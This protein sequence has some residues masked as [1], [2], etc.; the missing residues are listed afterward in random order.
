MGSALGH[1][2]LVKMIQDTPS[3]LSF[4]QSNCLS[5]CAYSCTAAACVCFWLIMR[6]I[7]S[8]LVPQCSLQP[9]PSKMSQT[10]Q[11]GNRKGNRNLLFINTIQTNFIWPFSDG[12]KRRTRVSFKK[13][14]KTEIILN[15]RPTKRQKAAKWMSAFIQ[16]CWLSQ[17]T[18]SDQI[19]IMS[20][21]QK[22]ILVCLVRSLSVPSVRL[23][24]CPISVTVLTFWVLTMLTCC[25]ERENCKC[26]VLGGPKCWS[27]IEG[28]SGRWCIMHHLLMSVIIW[29]VIVSFAEHQEAKNSL[30]NKLIDF[31][32]VYL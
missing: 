10:P 22:C 8:P 6:L 14:K 27:E 16:N 24:I 2:E 9:F 13:N 29:N 17:D 1:G 26:E 31:E 23:C 5:L 18:E 25:P 12:S 7:Y 4:S 19:C 20:E 30:K 3:T 11:R 15:D 21:K 28:L 32:Q